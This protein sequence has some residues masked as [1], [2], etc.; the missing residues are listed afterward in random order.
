MKLSDTTRIVNPNELIVHD[1][2]KIN[3][4]LT[5]E[6]YTALKENIMSSGQIT[7]IIV[8]GNN[9]VVDGR[10]RLKAC[11]ELGIEIKVT[12]VFDAKE[13]D[14]INIVTSSESGRHTSSTQKAIT[15]Y[16]TYTL[17][18]GTGN[19]ISTEKAAKMHG[20]S[21]PMLDMTKTIM[22]MANGTTDFTTG[23][24]SNKRVV[25]KKEE[26]QRILKV[27]N[28][29]DQIDK[30]WND[31]SYKFSF[32]IPPYMV[33]A[34]PSFEQPRDTNSIRPI[35]NGLRSFLESGLVEVME[36]VETDYSLMIETSVGKGDFAKFMSG[37][38][39][40]IEPESLDM[41]IGYINTIYKMKD[42]K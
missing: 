37:V 27:F 13:D 28:V 14:L 36:K 22:G 5:S 29:Q 26:C 30:M 40:K 16:R 19:S 3:P 10:H 15:A 41:L 42:G 20:I 38:Q 18:R 12:D 34:Y 32:H 1:V 8:V 17:K 35:L 6:E 24:N 31:K 33:A 7:P 2:A 11:R 9:L 39:C 4:E 25:K 21:K 23:S